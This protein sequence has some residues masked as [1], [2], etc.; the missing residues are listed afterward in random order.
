MRT[1]FLA[2]L[3]LL[4]CSPP[5][6][7]ASTTSTPAAAPTPS[8]V[9]TDPVERAIASL[10]DP[11][12][13]LPPDPPPPVADLAH[14]VT[15]KEAALLANPA[16]ANVWLHADKRTLLLTA[17]SHLLADGGFG[18][19]LRSE[20][21]KEP[22]LKSAAIELYAIHARIGRFPTDFEDKVRAHLKGMENTSHL[23]V[24]SP[25][26]KGQV[27]H[28]YA[29]LAAWL[30]RDRPQYIREMLQSRIDGPQRWLTSSPDQP[31]LLTY[32]AR[33][34]DALE[35]L[36]ILSELT[37][38]EKARLALLR[39][40][41]HKPTAADLERAHK[42]SGESNIS[43]KEAIDGGVTYIGCRWGGNSESATMWYVD[44]QIVKAINGKALQM[45]PR[46]AMSWIKEGQQP[47]PSG[48]S[49]E[50][51]LRATR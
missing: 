15:A 9:P 38:T 3:S 35:R 39:E 34:E 23:G 46:L 48:V 51:G 45:V 2:L 29:H 8:S 25:Y 13:L 32:L 18:N 47:S 10:D 44:G 19:P 41:S 27:P 26:E 31:P 30:L 49:A 5:V 28:S 16:Y 12:V 22:D 4:A 37:S 7:P 14:E 21:N 42:A 11:S 20:L 43:C 40:V 1:V 33:E 6:S 17:V 24:W 36:V 50:A